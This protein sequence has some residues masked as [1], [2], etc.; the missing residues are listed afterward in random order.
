MRTGI[1]LAALAVA[2]AV[3]NAQFRFFD[4]NKM[5][6]LSI[7]GGVVTILLVYGVG[8]ALYHV[9]SSEPSARGKVGDGAGVLAVGGV[10][11]ALAGF[12]TMMTHLC[13]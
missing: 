10:L 6:A 7:A 12:F 3:S 4:C 8:E 11:V 13:P 9:A 5:R 1:R 2:F